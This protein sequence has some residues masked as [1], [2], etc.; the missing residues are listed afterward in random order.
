M[1][2]YAIGA[3]EVGI[4]S[5]VLSTGGAGRYSGSVLLPTPEISRDWIHGGAGRITGTVE[6]KATP[7][8]YLH[9]RVRLHREVDGLLIRQTW[10]DGAGAYQFDDLDPFQGYSVISHDYLH[11]YRAVIADNITPEAPQ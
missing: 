8:T 3:I 1:A 7:V 2:E 9:R 5:T 4:T 6:E 11:N 10:S